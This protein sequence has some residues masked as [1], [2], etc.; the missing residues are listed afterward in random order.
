MNAAAIRTSDRP[1]RLEELALDAF[2]THLEVVGPHEIASRLRIG[3]ASAGDL[4]VKLTRAE[5]AF[6]HHGVA[7][8]WWALTKAGQV[9]WL[10]RDAARVFDLS[11]EPERNL[12]GVE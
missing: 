1:A 9:E 11:V 2:L 7:R 12:V 4:L 8:G 3:Y 5:L 10:R 6:E